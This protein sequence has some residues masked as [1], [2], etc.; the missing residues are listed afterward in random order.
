MATVDRIVELGGEAVEFEPIQVDFSGFGDL[1]SADMQID[2]AAY[3]R[4]YGSSQITQKTV[5]EIVA[6]NEADSTVRIP[7]GHGRFKG[8]LDVQLS[9]EEHQEL[10]DRLNAEGIKY[11]ETPMGELDIDIVLGINNRGAG[12]AAAAKYPA[13]TVPMGYRDSGRPAGITFIG[14]PFT[15]D[16]LLKIGYAFEQGTNFRK[17]PAGYE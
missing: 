4:D 14:R 13:F 9:E 17:N 12:F 7:Y 16:Q 10:K 8:M 2:L 15:E 5:E 3:L 1:L 6:Y 11:F